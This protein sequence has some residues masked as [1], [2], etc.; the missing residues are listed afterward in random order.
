LQN[1]KLTTPISIYTI[2]DMQNRVV[3]ISKFLSLVLRHQPGK[4]GLKLDPAA[5]SAGY[6]ESDERADA[7][8]WLSLLPFGERSLVDGQGSTGIPGSS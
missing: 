3:K 4:I 2:K 6:L 1:F 5:G 8:R 7:S